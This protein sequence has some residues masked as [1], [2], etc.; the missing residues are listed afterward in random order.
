MFGNIYGAKRIN[1]YQQRVEQA[2][3]THHQET[4]VMGR[5]KYCCSLDCR[6]FS[7]TQQ[8]GLRVSLDVVIAVAFHFLMTMFG[9]FS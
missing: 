1:Q 7:T 4:V 3:M 9:M 8:S 2:I 6:T 5:K